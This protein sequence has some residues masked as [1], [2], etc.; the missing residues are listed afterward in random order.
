M[1]GAADGQQFATLG[2]VLSRNQLAGAA[3]A[4]G[5]GLVVGTRYFCLLLRDSDGSVAY[6][7]A[8][9]LVENWVVLTPLVVPKPAHDQVI[10]SGLPAGC[11]Q[12]LL[13]SAT[14]QRVAQTAAN[15]S[16]QLLLS[17]LPAGLCLV[18]I[19]AESGTRVGSL[20]L[21]KE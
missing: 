21:V 2:T 4:F 19:L 6:S 7:P 9:S 10:I 5:A 15:G 16:G 18:N 14:G 1:Q 13:Y 17:G 12:L 8:I 3:Y 20:R 11:C